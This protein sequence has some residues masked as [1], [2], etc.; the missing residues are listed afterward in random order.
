MSAEKTHTANQKFDNLVTILIASTAIWVAITAYFENY[1]SNIADQARLQAQ[2]NVIK[3]TQ[4]E[5]NGN[6]RFSYDWQEAYQTWREIDWQESTA[7]QNGD[8]AAERRYQELKK[9]IEPLSGLL[10][11][12]YFDPETGRTDH[13]LYETDQYYKEAVYY[14][15]LYLAEAD[16]GKFTDDIADSLVVQITLLTVSLSLFGLSLAIQGRVR[17]LFVVIGSGMVGLCMIWLSWSMIELAIRPAVNQEAI[18]AYSE[19]M[20]LA[21]QYRYEDA[22]E[23]FTAA[24]QTDPTYARAYYQRGNAYLYIDDHPAAIADMEKARLHGL[25]DV[26]TNWNLGWSYYLTGQ[27]EKGIQT[28]NRILATKP[29]VIGMRANQAISY[30]ALGNIAAA[31]EQYDLLLQEAETQVKNAR[32]NKEEP[33]VLLW[34][35]MDASAQDLQSLIEQLE[36]RPKSWSYAPP[37]NLVHG[38]HV[39]IRDFAQQQM[40]RLKEATVALEYTGQL[41]AGGEVMQITNLVLATVAKKDD[42]GAIL[43]YR[44]VQNS[45]ITYGEKSFIIEYTYTG[46]APKRMVW[47][48]YV[49]GQEYQSLREFSPD[50]ISNSATWYRIF[51]Y[52]FSRIFILPSGEYTVEIY[53]DERLIRTVH[54]TIQ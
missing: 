4:T 12:P 45:T 41:P 32:E 2:Q 25:D 49:N 34:Y 30:L 6:I 1:A 18:R 54:F 23:Q 37:S 22:I 33:P 50:D 31:Q 19:G 29:E 7:R 20:G 5:V 13:W 27:Y 48:T 10:S 8:T 24:V 40:I 38:D 9:R 36:N 15:E 39:A 47:K 17:W 28:N 35:Y 44:P 3:A 52:E 42:S 26:T 14:T 43:E 21:Y 53:A 51:G 11:H 46:P 16:L